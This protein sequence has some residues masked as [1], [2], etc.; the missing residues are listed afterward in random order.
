MSKNRRDSS[1]LLLKGSL[2]HLARRRWSLGRSRRL[3]KGFLHL[4]L[5]ILHLCSAGRTALRIY[6]SPSDNSCDE[7]DDSNDDHSDP[8][9][10]FSAH[11]DTPP[12][13]DTARQ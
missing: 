2:H 1:G 8:K 11:P 10:N 4:L 7:H 6:Q 9:G 12:Y 13:L 3:L 5:Q